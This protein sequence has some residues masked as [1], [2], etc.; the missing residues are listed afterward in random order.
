M[1][2]EKVER[3]NQ[4]ARKAKAEGLTSEELV[5]QKQLRDE[6]IAAYR[7]S[8]REQLH[9]ITVIDK[10]G[11]DITPEKLKESKKNRDRLN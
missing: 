2:K 6:Y 3:I 9:S 5:E 11:N 4:L 8:L 10:E 1:F 7:E